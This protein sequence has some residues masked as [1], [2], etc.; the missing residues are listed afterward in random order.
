MAKKFKDLANACWKGYKAVGLKD[1]D[2]KKVPNCVPV[3][4]EAGFCPECNQDPCVCGGNHIQEVSSDLVKKA[5]DA[6]FAKGKDDQGHRFVKKAYDKGQKESDAMAKK[7]AEQ[8]APVAPTIDRKYIKGT[9]EWKAHKEKSK[10]INGHPTNNVKE[11]VEQIAERDEIQSAD[12][13]LTASGKKRAAQHIVFHNQDDLEPRNK[14]EKEEK[15][16]EESKLM[17]FSE[18]MNL[19]KADMGDVIKDFQSSDAPQFAGKS[20]E[21]RKEMAIAA[22]MQADREVKEEVEQIDELS[23]GTLA[24]YAKKATHD[25]RI[26]QRIAKDFEAQSNK[27]RRPDM[28]R[29]A[30]V[31]RQHYQAKAHK[32][33]AGVGSA[34]DRLAKEEVEQIDE[35]SKKTLGSYVSKASVDMANRTADATKKKTLAG[36]DYAHNI[37]RG[38]DAKTADKHMKKDYEDAKPDVNKAVKRMHNINKAVNRLTKEDVEF[39]EEGNLMSNKISYKDFLT[40]IEEALWPGTPEHKAKFGQDQSRK[41]GQETR[42]QHGTQKGTGSGVVHTR[43]YDKAEKEEQPEQQKRG[44]GRPAGS[45]SGARN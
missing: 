5:R 22:K 29:A 3:S 24:S 33:E 8:H 45:K 12:Y 16:M 28:K 20:K 38:M 36:A 23:K 11:E 30:D 37:S 35:I 34:V 6:A 40:K 32:R 27:V 1:K 15:K 14:K 7:M 19:A 43:D 41:A 31:L 44:R 26:Q 17:S 25:S 10:P 13:K 9:P 39:D 42:T 21:K 18:K 2:G 4:E